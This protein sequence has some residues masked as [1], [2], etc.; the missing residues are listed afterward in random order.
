[1]DQLKVIGKPRRRVDGAAKVAAQTLFADDISLPRMLHCKML[2][3]HVPHALIEKIDTVRAAQHPGVF[4]VLT[5][6]DFPVE[7]G[8]LPVTQDERVLCENKVRFVGDPVA[9]VIARDEFT[10]Q[11]AL[12]LIEVHYQPLPVVTDSIDALANPEARLHEYGEEGNIH[13]RI[14]Y[15]FGDVEE[16]LADSDHVFEDLFFYEGSTHLPIEQHAA[17]AARDPNGRLTLWSSTQTPHYV[18]LALAK[19]LEFPP[20]R[21][22]VIACPNGGGFGG[23]S[24]PFNHEIIVAKAALLLGRPVKIC[25]TR[26]EVFY[27]IITAAGTPS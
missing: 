13:R 19:A 4:L 2:R 24:E 9:A 14:S 1:V 8:I 7:Y 22:R 11:Q 3:S 21:I 17:V 27:N 6:K 12:D 26:E 15:E 18:H 20:A 5:G 10:A 23:K 16:A 25:L